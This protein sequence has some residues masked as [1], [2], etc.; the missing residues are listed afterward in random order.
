[1]NFAAIDVSKYAV[2]IFI[3]ILLFFPSLAL[4]AIVIIPLQL[5]IS[6][7]YQPQNS[8]C[9]AYYYTQGRDSI[10]GLKQ[11]CDNETAAN[12]KGANMAN[13]ALTMIGGTTQA[14]NLFFS[15]LVGF[16][17]IIVLDKH[18]KKD[19]H[20]QF[21]AGTTL[22]ISAVLAPIYLGVMVVF[23]YMT[24]VSSN[25]VLL[26]ASFCMFALYVVAGSLAFFGGCCVAKVAL[27]RGHEKEHG[28]IGL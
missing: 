9:T 13:Y 16:L 28:L 3:G 27:A 8:A 21:G 25:P 15:G 11:G 1:M 22:V 2:P 20:V 24:A 6:G 7:A 23:N 4:N 14:I 12:Q 18:M 26:A 17:S 5:A 19:V 10:P